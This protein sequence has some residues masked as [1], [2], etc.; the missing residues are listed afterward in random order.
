MLN[1]IIQKNET[2]T[3][4]YTLDDYLLFK[5]KS[6]STTEKE[7]FLFFDYTYKYTKIFSFTSFKQAEQSLKERFEE[8]KNKFNIKKEIKQ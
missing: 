1:T 7:T 5:I 6:F 8:Y 3:K 4:Y 2:F